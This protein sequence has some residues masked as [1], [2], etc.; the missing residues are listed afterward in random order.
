MAGPS[1]VPKR[2]GRTVFVER[3]PDIFYR[4]HKSEQLAPGRTETLGQLHADSQEFSVAGPI[5]RAIRQ[6]VQPRPL[7]VNYPSSCCGGCYLPLRPLSKT[8][9]RQFLKFE[10]RALART[11]MCW[12]VKLESQNQVP[13]D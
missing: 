9:S 8:R 1:R 4:A 7:Q 6:K 12:R 13:E 5:P 2:L 3:N 11:E 10:G